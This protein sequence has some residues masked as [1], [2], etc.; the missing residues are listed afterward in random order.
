MWTGHRKGIQKLTFWKLALSFFGANRG[1][2]RYVVCGAVIYKKME[3]RYWLV[4]GNVK[5]N[6]Q[7]KLFE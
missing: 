4:P 7:N 2:V 6:C 5:N 3:M 1:I